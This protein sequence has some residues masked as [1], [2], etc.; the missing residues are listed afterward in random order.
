VDFVY[1]G[2]PGEVPEGDLYPYFTKMMLGG[3]EYH[4]YMGED[5]DP[6]KLDIC[7]GWESTQCHEREDEE[8]YPCDEIK[9]DD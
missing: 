9:G 7:V 5:A 1:K 4:S 3:L 6:V 8:N 2:S